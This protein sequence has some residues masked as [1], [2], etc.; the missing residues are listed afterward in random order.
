[1]VTKDPLV[2]ELGVSRKTGQISINQNRHPHSRNTELNPL[3]PSIP[4]IHAVQDIQ[5]RLGL[6][7]DPDTQLKTDV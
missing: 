2:V 4:K 6:L 1:M 7:M 5:Q 3:T